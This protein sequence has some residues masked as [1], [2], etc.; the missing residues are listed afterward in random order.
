MAAAFL[1]WQVRRVYAPL[2]DAELSAR[3][4][5][6]P[7]PPP[8]RPFHANST[9]GDVAEGSCFGGL[10]WA[11]LR[12]GM[13]DCGDVDQQ[14]VRVEMLLAM[15]LQARA[16]SNQT[17]ASVYTHN[18]VDPMPRLSAP[19]NL[20]GPAHAAQRLVLAINGNFGSPMFPRSALRCLLCLFNS[21]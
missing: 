13:G 4:L 19:A 14:R 10:F 15:P 9:V 6:V 2:S 7:R 1:I 12:S 8:K 18:A 5:D 16:D 20:A 21:T 11:A 17:R 3:G